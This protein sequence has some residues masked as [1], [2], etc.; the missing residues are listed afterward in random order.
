MPAAAVA[1]RTPPTGGRSGKRAG[2]SGEIVVAMGGPAIDCVI[3]RRPDTSLLGQAGLQG[4][5]S[6]AKRTHKRGHR[7][8]ISG[9]PR[10]AFKCVSRASPTYVCLCPPTLFPL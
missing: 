1:S 7:A 4:G 8:P 6:E 3:K 10:S 5:Q 9:C 2:A